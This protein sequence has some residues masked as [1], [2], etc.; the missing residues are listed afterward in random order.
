MSQYA[1][2]ICVQASDL[3]TGAEKNNNK[4]Y[5]MKENTDGTFTATYGRIGNDPA[6]VSYPMSKWDSIL[7]QKTTKVRNGYIYKDITALKSTVVSKTLKDVIDQH[8]L[9]L[10][11]DLQRYSK[12][13]IIDNYTVTSEQVTQVQ[14]DKAQEILN[15]IADM[16]KYSV[17][18]PTDIDKQLVELFAIIPRKMKKVQDYLLNGNTDKKEAQNILQREQDTVDVMRGQVSIQNTSTANNDATLEDI[19]G[20]KVKKVDDQVT[21]DKIKSMMTSDSQRFKNAYEVVKIDTQASFENQLKQ[22]VKHWTKLLW[23]GSRNEN[24]LNILK[25]GLK[26]RPTCAV[27]TGSMFG[28][29]LY[30]ADKF[31]KSLGYTSSKGSHWARGNSSQAFLALYEINTGMELRTDKHDSEFYTFDYKKLKSKGDYDS[32]FA[33]G[34]IDLRN[35]EYIIYKETQCTIKYLVEIEG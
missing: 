3:D 9:K 22:S 27:Q 31:Q 20:I 19:L 1:Y 17:I 32:L 8:I 12:Q 28:P 10:L 26:I 21:I 33:K 6:T 35:N 18:R 29:G 24:W 16:L 13:S 23:H 7:K 5:E 34:G 14:I 30:F 25:T 4:F 15:K 2:L 11:S